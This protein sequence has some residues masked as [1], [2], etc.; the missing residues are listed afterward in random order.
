MFEFSII[1]TGQQIL[2]PK[3]MS[4]TTFPYKKSG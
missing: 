1:M 3:R 4:L 2:L